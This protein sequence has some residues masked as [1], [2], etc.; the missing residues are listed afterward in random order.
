MS[1]SCSASPVD[2]QAVRRILYR[3]WACRKARKWNLVDVNDIEKFAVDRTSFCTPSN[4]YM[5]RGPIM[6]STVASEQP[7]KYLND[8][9]DLP[10]DTPIAP[11]LISN[12]VLQQVS[13]T[14]CNY[15][16]LPLGSVVFANLRDKVVT[17]LKRLPQSEERDEYMF[18]PD[19]KG[20]ANVYS[21]VFELLL[22]NKG[23]LAICGGWVLS[24][25]MS[26]LK[27]RGTKASDIDMFF[28][29][30]KKEEAENII[31]EATK[32]LSEL[33]LRLGRASVTVKKQMYVTT[34]SV[35]KAIDIQF[36]HRIYP[37]LDLIIGGFDI[38][39]CSCAVF[40]DEKEELQVKLTEVAA[41]SIAK[42]TIPV[43]ISRRSVSFEQRICK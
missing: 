43:D 4:R 13:S 41:W 32:S 31:Y 14:L 6:F 40:Y 36:I 39:P 20:L 37:T 8:Q 21:V 30:C 26:S 9:P 33:V 42:C 12:A 34:I 27:D 25:I 38:A 29:N 7:A 5:E 18:N 3:D 17:L 35:G 19:R 24:K 15:H 10:L 1:Y 11:F 23:K 2:P 16:H 22:V 28:Y